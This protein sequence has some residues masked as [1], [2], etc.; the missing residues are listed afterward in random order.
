MSS[1]SAAER[2]SRRTIYTTIPFLP[3]KA[4]Q[5]I[6]EGNSGRKRGRLGKSSRH[7]SGS[8]L[9]YAAYV[10]SYLERREPFA[11][12]RP[13]QLTHPLS[14]WG[15]VYATSWDGWPRS[16]CPRSCGKPMTMKPEMLR[17][18]GRW[19]ASGGA[20]YC[21]GNPRGGCHVQPSANKQTCYCWKLS[22]QGHTTYQL[23]RRRIVSPDCHLRI[24][25][26]LQPSG[27]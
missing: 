19:P 27:P 4:S 25:N 9:S 8:P 18:N 11:R 15:H 26:T 23:K 16:L 6:F 13:G 2:K 10:F 24:T 22:E 12:V 3:L 1:M 7:R 21:I 14:P 17:P 20:S 5:G